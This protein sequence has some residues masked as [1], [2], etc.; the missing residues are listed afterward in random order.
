MFRRAKSNPVLA[1]DLA[2]DLAGE[3]KRSQAM[4]RAA[5]ALLNGKQDSTPINGKR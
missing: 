2:R 4:T 1:R 3:A 5:R